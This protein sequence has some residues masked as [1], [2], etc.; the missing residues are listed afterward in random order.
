MSAPPKL[1]PGRGK[2]E[3]ARSRDSRGSSRLTA[4]KNK[5]AAQVYSVNLLP[6]FFR[7]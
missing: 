4:V 2:A 7:T 6:R 3:Q 5:S 1:M